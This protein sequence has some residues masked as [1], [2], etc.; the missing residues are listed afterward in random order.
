[1]KKIICVLMLLLAL[2]FSACTYGNRSRSSEMLRK[3]NVLN[4][5]LIKEGDI[6]FLHQTEKW[7]D[8]ESESFT[9]TTKCCRNYIWAKN[10]HTT[11]W[12]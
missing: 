4:Y 2:C 3:N 6:W 10:L 9:V 7:S 11:I 5:V 8:T 12:D 1:M